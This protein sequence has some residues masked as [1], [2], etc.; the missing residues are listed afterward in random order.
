MRLGIDLPEQESLGEEVAGFI[1]I[2]D[3]K[4]GTIK[5]PVNFKLANDMWFIGNT[6]FISSF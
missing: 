6:W 2:N 4:E 1:V 3:P 5:T